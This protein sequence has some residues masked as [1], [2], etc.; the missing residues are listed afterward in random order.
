MSVVFRSPTK[1]TDL[2]RVTKE[3]TV[4]FFPFAI[5]TKQES[6][7]VLLNHTFLSVLQ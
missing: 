5:T 3:H 6:L 7:L 4:L 2:E 1:M